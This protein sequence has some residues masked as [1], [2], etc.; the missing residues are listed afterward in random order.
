MTSTTPETAP[1]KRLYKST[2]YGVTVYMPNGKPLIFKFGRYITGDEQE[3]A[4]LDSAI[5]RN[6]F[7]GNIYIDPQARTI[8]EAEENPMKALRDSIIADYLAQQ[9][10]QL[11]PKQDMGSYTQGQLKTANT[12]DVASVVANGDGAARLMAAASNLG[13]AAPTPAA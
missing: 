1:E 3:I 8:S 4:Y 12:S 5:E 9:A 6:E 11:D 2:R 13:K 7:A 10:K